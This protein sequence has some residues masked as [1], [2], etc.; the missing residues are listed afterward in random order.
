VRVQRKAVV[1]KVLA[2]RLARL[3]FAH[4]TYGYR[5]LWALL[6]FAEGVLTTRG[7]SYR[8]RKLRKPA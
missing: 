3:I 5:R 7:D 2:L 6:R 8:T 1:D 4:P